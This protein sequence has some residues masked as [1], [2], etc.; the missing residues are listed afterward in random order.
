[1]SNLTV[2]I[3]FTKNTGEPALGLTLNEIDIYL[4][5]Q[6]K[7]TGVDTVIWNGAENPTA[8]M[9]NVGRYIR[10]LAGADLDTYHYYAAAEY[11]GA[12]VLDADWALGAV[13]KTVIFPAG[14]I[15][16]P[17]IVTSTTTLLPIFGVDVWVT[18][19]IAGTNTIWRGTTDA[20]GATR[21]I[22][23]LQPW[24]DAGVYYF[25]RQL[26]GYNF[27]NPDTET[28]V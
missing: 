15:E 8:E 7:D 20:L 18:T 2:S 23:G 17:Y 9:D 19:D 6:H 16:W 25:W 14:A 26:T 3:A 10:I 27:S 28:V 22:F 13:G 5:R 24:L 4:T 12:T 1:M 11:T 21:N